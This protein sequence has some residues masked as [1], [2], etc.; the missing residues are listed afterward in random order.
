[1]NSREEQGQILLNE[2]LPAEFK[3][4]VRAIAD[5]S[6]GLQAK[7]YLSKP[8][9][10]LEWAIPTAV[11]IYL[12]K[13]FFDGFLKEMGKDSYAALKEMLGKQKRKSDWIEE[14]AVLARDKELQIV[15]AGGRLKKRSD[16]Q[17]LS[18]SI[19]AYTETGKEIKFLFNRTQSQNQWNEAIF[20]M[21]SL[22]SDHLSNYPNDLL[23]IKLKDFDDRINRRYFGTFDAVGK[24]WVFHDINK[25]AQKQYHH[26]RA[27]IL[28][29]LRN[30][31]SSNRL[32]EAIEAIDGDIH[33]KT[34]NNDLILFKNR[35]NMIL[36]QEMKGLLTL[37]EKDVK[38]NRLVNDF[39]LFLDD[40][41]KKWII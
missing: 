8:F 31:V 32:L 36:E 5:S 35:Y 29:K 7:E 24:D 25:I 4:S 21:K 28:K 15:M 9:A 6:K 26:Q 37:Q 16:D 41:E 22:L 13:S 40:L 38:H 23:T 1:M 33:G 39:L 3:K 12:T 27:D 20:I 18:F 17:V 34:S 2:I 11:I 19:V 14:L 30:L 10:S